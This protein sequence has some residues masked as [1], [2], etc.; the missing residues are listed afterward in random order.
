MQTA[1]HKRSPEDI[2]RTDAGSTSNRVLEDIQRQGIRA[3]V[4]LIPVVDLILQLIERIERIDRRKRSY[5]EV[6]K[7]FDYILIFHHTAK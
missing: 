4:R 1:Y 3:S 7:F 5:I 2:H 6:R